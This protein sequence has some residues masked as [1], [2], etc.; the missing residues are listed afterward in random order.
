M[1]NSTKEIREI[2]LVFWEFTITDNPF[3][4]Q[5]K[6]VNLYQGYFIS[7]ETRQHF[8]YSELKTKPKIVYN[9]VQLVRIFSWTCQ[10]H[11]FQNLAHLSCS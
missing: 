9:Q 1:Y 6:S 2:E 10:F 7:T 8:T 4:W 5:D 11:I 3:P